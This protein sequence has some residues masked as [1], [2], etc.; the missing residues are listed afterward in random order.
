MFAPS[1][2]DTTSLSASSSASVS[3]S[4]A[5][6][7]PNYTA[8]L[9]NSGSVTVF[10]EFGSSTATATTSSMPVP[11]GLVEVVHTGV[12]STHAAAITSAGSTTIYMTAGASS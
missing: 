9:F 11:A 12:G 7:N 5:V 3:G 4:I 2:E 8:R 6:S 1:A 10:V